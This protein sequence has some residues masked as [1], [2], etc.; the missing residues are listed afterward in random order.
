MIQ[1][2]IPAH[3]TASRDFTT[4]SRRLNVRRVERK[5]SVLKSEFGFETPIS[6]EKL[7]QRTLV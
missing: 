3:D 5:P 6:H 2:I 7:P 1:P 4:V